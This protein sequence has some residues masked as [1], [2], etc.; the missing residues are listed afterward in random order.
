VSAKGH[1][2]EGQEARM[3][4]C[5]VLRCA[6]PAARV[7]Q[8]NTPGTAFKE[9][10]VCQRHHDQIESGASWN[11]SPDRGEILMAADL[12]LRLLDWSIGARTTSE[13]GPG[14]MVQLDVGRNGQLLD[15]VSIW[16]TDDQIRALGA[17]L[18]S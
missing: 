14:V 17:R 9:A 8:I 12:P 2:F 11:W 4:E 5:D 16:L 1:N 7:L 6:E 15:L 3:T 13:A 18:G 10:I